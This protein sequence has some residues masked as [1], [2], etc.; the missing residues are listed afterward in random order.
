MTFEVVAVVELPS[1]LMTTELLEAF[2]PVLTLLR[3]LMLR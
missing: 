1:A 2:G 3:L